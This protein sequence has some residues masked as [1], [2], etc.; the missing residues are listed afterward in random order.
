MVFA[1]QVSQKKGKHHTFPHFSACMLGGSEAP[2]SLFPIHLWWIDPHAATLDNF[3]QELKVEDVKTNLSVRDFPQKLQLQ[4]VK[5]KPELAVPLRGQSEHDPTLTER[6][7]QPSRGKAS[8]S[9]FRGTFCLAKR[10]L[11]YIRRFRKMHFVGDVPQKLKVTDVKNE[12]FVR[13][14]LRKLQL[15]LVK[16]EPELAVPLRGRS[17]RDPTRTVFRKSRAAKLPHPS[18]EARF[19]LQNTACRTSAHFE[20]HISCKT[21]L[22]N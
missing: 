4:L 10:S 11:S 2:L 3:P 5:I 1:P 15:Q 16:I 12:A 9:I 19:V 17:E 18:S 21:S 22:K 8:P 6:V 13:D 20:K 14:F 7:P